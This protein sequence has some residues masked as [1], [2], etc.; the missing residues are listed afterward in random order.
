M[1]VKALEG[2][3]HLQTDHCVTGSLRHLYA[4]HGHDLSE[5]MLLGLGEGVG[6]AY[7]HFKGQ[8]PF[9]GGRAQPKPSMEEIA[10]TRTGVVVKARASSS[11]AAAASGLLSK[12][13]QG[14]PAMLQVDMG[15]LKYFDFGGTDYHFGGHVVVACGHDAA[16]D[17][18]LI[19]DRDRALHPV[20]MRDLT[21]ARGSRH[22]PFPPNRRTWDLDFSGYH[23]PRRDAI[24]AAARN[25][26]D[27]ML[28]PPIANIGVKGIRKAA[29]EI[30][31]WEAQLEPSQL[32][33]AL[34][35]AWIFIDK[36][37]GTGGGTFRRMFSRFL[38]EAAAATETPSL[39][40]ASREFGGIAD[41]WDSVAVQCR[42]AS[43]SSDPAAMS[44]CLPAIGRALAGVAD[45][46]DAGWQSL[47][48]CLNE[49]Q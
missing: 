47:Q 26:A 44:S 4:F 42:K 27:A 25:Q 10:A 12:L 49:E 45:R 20:A 28:A 21:A 38:R 8:L 30:G 31:K 32:K 11:D 37:G 3:R 16:T 5:D 15:F 22:K 17:T 2:F 48:E 19:A 9:L 33:G 24:L 6:F 18:V 40:T 1:M 43:E 46:E 36:T 7:F 14:E 13:A 41:A 39:E 23:A 35:N 34:F 29:A